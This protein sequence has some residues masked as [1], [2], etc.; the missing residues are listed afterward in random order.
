MTLEQEMK[1]SC[2]IIVGEGTAAEELLCR[3]RGAG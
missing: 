2:L 3:R 1:D